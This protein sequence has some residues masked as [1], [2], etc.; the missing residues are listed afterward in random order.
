MDATA[1]RSFI[2]A[3]LD[4]D[5]DVRRRAELQLKQ[6]EDQPNFTD[7]L[8]DLVSSEQNVTLQLPTAIY[9]KNRVNRAW[10]RSDHIT[11][12]S[13][14]PEDAKVRF[15]ERLLP[16]LAGSQA[17]VR[18]QLVPVL[19]RILH[20]DFPQSWPNFM[21]YTIQLLNTNTPASVMAGLQCLLAICRTYRFKSP[22]GETRAPFDKIVE[23]SFPR[24]LVVCQELV[25]QESD[26]AGEMLHIALKCYKHAT[27]LELSDFLRQNE[28]NLAW[29]TIFLET[30]SKPIPATAMQHEDPLERER[31]HWWK[32][33]KWA[34]FNLNRLYIRYE[35]VLGQLTVS[36][37]HGNPNSLMDNA[38]DDQKRF[39]KD[40]TAQV[41]PTIFN[42]YLQEIEKW[43]AKTTWLSRPCLS[44]TI[45]FLDECIRPKEMWAH[46]KTHL[47]TL[48]THFIFPVLCLSEDDLEKFEEEPEEYLHRKLNFYEE[49]SAPDVSAT[50]FLVTLTKARRKQTFEIL[51]F[52]NEVVTQYEASEPDKKNHIAKEGALRM[53]GTLAPV[54]L[55]KKSPIADQVEYFLVRFVFPDFS[56]EQGYL[57]ARACDTVEKFEQL[58]FKEQNNLLTVYRHILD[59]MADPKLPVRVT[60]ALALQPLIRHDIIRTS[61]Q[62]SIPT[63]MQQLLKLANEADIDALANVM[64]DFVEV[65]AAELTPFAVALSEQL[66]DTYLRIVR[67]LLENNQQRDD[68]DNEYGD[69]LDD[70]SITALGVLQTI[71]TLILTLESS[72]D[73]LLHIEGVLMPVIEITLRNKL[74]DLYNEVFEIIDSCTFAAKRISPIMWQ[75]FELVHA[76]FKSGAELYLEDMLP[77]LDNFV[78][79]GA[80]QLI[81]KPEYVQ[82]LFS[83]VSDMFMENRVGG[84]DRICACKL[85]EAMMLS[86]RGHIDDC[87]HGFIT[88]AMNVLS[89][90][91]VTIKSYKIHLMEMVI[92]A[93]YYN[94]LLALHILETQGW[95]N[96]FFSLWFGSMES[97]TRVHDKR[98]CIMAIVQLITIPNEQIPASVAVGW[99]R[100]LKGITIL[101]STLPAAMKIT[102]DEADREEALRDDFQLDSSAYYDEDEDWDDDGAQWEEGDAAEGEHSESKDESTAYLDFLNEEAQ[103]LQSAEGEVSDDDLGEDSVLLENPLD[104]IDPYMSFHVSLHRLQQEQPQ[105]YASLTS[106]LSPDEQAVITHVCAQAEAQA[107]QH[108]QAALAAQGAGMN[109]T[110]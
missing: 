56:N 108:Q 107:A 4:A 96:K 104:K 29:C 98:L 60:A 53:I 31:H 17:K 19:Q 40:F 39:A 36:R 79:F 51:K 43:V 2:V 54:I 10:E 105:F 85:A 28:V 88:I 41:A 74:Y 33:K 71:G 69:Y 103:K 52:I 94:P 106:Q 12:N 18:Q 70:K 102:D 110:S 66:R 100:L 87:V 78:Q 64:E 68:L 27:W 48:V 92:N 81:H 14:I 32:A 21:D 15:R 109:G 1:I 57:R 11:T 63:I 49:V 30:V 50:N 89:G 80:P 77:A 75:A 82:A 59:C 20:F 97:F 67:E 91:E 26:E 22:E 42:H 23:A 45:V 83:M 47:T 46:L 58:N 99:P 65:F 90:Q 86:L 6:A 76:T 101:F 55:G 7:I 37:R 3:T 38:S 13:V 95:T 8:L 44:Y 62:S 24:L 84:V 16:V 72:P 5:A 35:S 93:I 9:L 25:K 34:Y 61:M 73:V